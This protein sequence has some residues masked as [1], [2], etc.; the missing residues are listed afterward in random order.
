MLTSFKGWQYA[1][2]LYIEKIK[3]TIDIIYALRPHLL[4]GNRSSA[5]Y[6]FS[7]VLFSV[8]P[9]IAGLAPSQLAEDVGK[10]FHKFIHYE[11][12][13]IRQNLETVRYTFNLDVPVAI[14]IVKIAMR[15]SGMTAI[16]RLKPD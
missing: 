2:T 4:L 1:A 9:L 11:V 16:A 6:Y 14:V 12:E 13:R 5:E 10:K 7:Y 8:I 3:K 15:D